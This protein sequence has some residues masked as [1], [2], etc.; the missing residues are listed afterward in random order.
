MPPTPTSIRL[1][2]P[3]TLALLMPSSYCQ[4]SPPP[5]QAPRDLVPVVH[6][7]TKDPAAHCVAPEPLA[8]ARGPGLTATCAAPHLLCLCFPG[9]SRAE[10]GPAVPMGGGRP[11][12]GAMVRAMAGCYS[13][14]SLQRYLA[15]KLINPFQSTHSFGSLKPVLGSSGQH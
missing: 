9:E 15:M 8:G 2:I 12:L 13:Y 7:T 4:T 11:Q 5:E 6:S 3:P 10:L 14:A 1:R